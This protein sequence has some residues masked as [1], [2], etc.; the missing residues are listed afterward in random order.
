MRLTRRER[1]TTEYTRSLSRLHGTPPTAEPD[2]T[3]ALARVLRGRIQ[4]RGDTEPSCSHLTRGSGK[5]REAGL[6]AP[7]PPTHTRLHPW[8][9]HPNPRI[10]LWVSSIHFQNQKPE[11]MEGRSKSFT[12]VAQLLQC[13]PPHE[14][15]ARPA[16]LEGQGQ[17]GGRRGWRE[18]RRAR[19]ASR[20][21]R[22]GGPVR[23][24]ERVA[25]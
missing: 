3:R 18:G 15:A 6:G 19:N 10:F 5:R 13:L 12:S 8:R 7:P 9:S 23:D 11:S 21:C 4:V 20:G 22:G 16:G 25:S 17:R 2:S 24:A 1:T 14:A